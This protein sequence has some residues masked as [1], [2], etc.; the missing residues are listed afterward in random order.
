MLKVRPAL[1]RGGVNRDMTDDRQ[2]LG[3]AYLPVFVQDVRKL[4][5]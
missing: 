5:E 2:H 1:E 4:L 3:E